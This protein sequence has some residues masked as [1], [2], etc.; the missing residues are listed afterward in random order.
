MLYE[1]TEYGDPSDPS[2]F[3]FPKAKGGELEP[4]HLSK[5]VAGLDLGGTL[6]GF[7]S[8]FITWAADESVP[9]ERRVVLSTSDRVRG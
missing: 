5:L 2:T 8:T 7:R 1:A 6:H 3:G 4:W 9:R